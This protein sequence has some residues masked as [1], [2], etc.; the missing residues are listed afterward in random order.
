MEPYYPAGYTQEEIAEMFGIKKN[1]SII[2]PMPQ[3]PAKPLSPIDAYARADTGR[4]PEAGRGRSLVLDYLEMPKNVQSDN[5][6]LPYLNNT[7]T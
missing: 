6:L 3:P 7:L 4:E 2:P 5:A 1:D